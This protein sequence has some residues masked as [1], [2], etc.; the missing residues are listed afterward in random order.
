LYMHEDAT[1]RRAA[2][3][4]PLR[5]A[6]VLLGV[7]GVAGLGCSPAINWRFDTY[8]RVHAKAQAGNQLTFVYF[9]NWYSVECTQFEENVLKQPA[10]PE[11]VSD[12]QC[13]LLSFDWDQPLAEEWEISQPPAYAIVDPQDRV[14]ARGE[15]DI[16]LEALLEAIQRA[17]DEFAPMTQPAVPP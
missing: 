17:K 13:V 5:C 11:A 7:A 4:W 10:V 14:L 9:R 16:T 6:G 12:M 15:G 2:R 3:S 8:E 1:N